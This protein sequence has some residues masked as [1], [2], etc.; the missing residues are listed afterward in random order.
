MPDANS[1]HVS[2]QVDTFC[3]FKLKIMLLSLNKTPGGFYKNNRVPNKQQRVSNDVHSYS[4][5]GCK[6]A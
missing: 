3:Y 1:N 5:H 2:P 6:H 4:S